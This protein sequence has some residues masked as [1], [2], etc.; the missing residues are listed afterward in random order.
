MIAVH[1]GIV[2]LTLFPNKE[3]SHDK[4]AAIHR[5]FPD[6]Q[7]DRKKNGDRGRSVL[8]W[9]RKL[10]RCGDFDLVDVPIDQ[11]IHLELQYLGI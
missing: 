8:E 4:L 6:S 2:S 5:N 10:R 3:V 9:K 1:S 11:Q 7:A